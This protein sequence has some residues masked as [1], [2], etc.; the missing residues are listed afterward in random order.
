MCIQAGPSP[1][2]IQT[3]RIFAVRI[4]HV[5]LTKRVGVLVNCVH[6][7]ANCVPVNCVHN[8]AN[9]VPVICVHR[10]DPLTQ[11]R[12]RAAIQV[13][14]ADPF[15]ATVRHRRP[16]YILCVCTA[17]PSAYQIHT[18]DILYICVYD[19]SYIYVYMTYHIYVYDVPMSKV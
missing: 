6:N 9:C 13:F 11:Q 7:P 5:Y 19:V 12:M 16:I 1:C 8:P 4:L 14:R 2:K 17:R 10:Q 18:V 15:L 3:V